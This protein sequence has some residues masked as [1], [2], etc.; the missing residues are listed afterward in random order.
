MLLEMPE[1]KAETRSFFSLFPL[2]FHPSPLVTFDVFSHRSLKQQE[3]DETWRLL[4]R[5]LTSCS[6]LGVSGLRKHASCVLIKHQTNYLCINDD[7]GLL[8]GGCKM[9]V[10]I[11]VGL[12]WYKNVYWM[13]MDEMQLLFL[14]LFSF[15]HDKIYFNTLYLLPD[16]KNKVLNL[17]MDKSHRTPFLDVSLSYSSCSNDSLLGRYSLQILMASLHMSAFWRVTENYIEMWGSKFD[18]SPQTFQFKSKMKRVS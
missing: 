13:N 3:K 6:S 4:V 1:I 2:N 12:S 16:R 7:G 8:R 10:A 11:W 5:S 17:F 14:F 15:K 18:T 9:F